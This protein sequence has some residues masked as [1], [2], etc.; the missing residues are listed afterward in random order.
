MEIKRKFIVGMHNIGFWQIAD[1]D[2]RTHFFPSYLHRTSSLSGSEI[3]IHT[4]ND[5][6]NDKCNNNNVSIHMDEP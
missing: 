4:K 2:I 3:N 5:N 6:Y 1:S